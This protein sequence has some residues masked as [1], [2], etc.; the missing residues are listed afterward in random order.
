MRNGLLCAALAAAI[1]IGAR[2]ASAQLLYGMETGTPANPDGFGPNGGGVTVSQNAV[3]GVTQ[4][5]NSMQVSVVTGATFVGA[6]TTTIAPPLDSP[7]IPTQSIF[8]DYTLLTAYP[9]SFALMGVTMFGSNAPLGQFGLQAQFADFEHLEGKAAGT[10]TAQ[11]DLT[12]ATNPL[13]FTPNQSYNQI[14]TGGIPAANQLNPS[15]FQLFFNKDS[16]A[17]LL[18]YIDNVRIAPEP[19]SLFGGCAALAG[20]A[21]R[22]RQR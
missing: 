13:D 11:L 16:T 12:S 8:V 19:T 10:Y 2:S 14:F 6:L 21:L 4:G 20:L 22:R 5:L 9:G 1:M 15:G 17:P 3:F 7:P 18:V